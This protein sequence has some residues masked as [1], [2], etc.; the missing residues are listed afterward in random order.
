MIL[1]LFLVLAF[2]LAGETL[3]HLSPLPVPGPVIGMVLLAAAFALM[4]GLM[5]VLRPLSTT[6]LGNLSLLFVP[7]GV[8]IV[9]HAEL[10]Q[11]DGLAVVVAIAV[12]T[13]L[14][15]AASAL[16]FQWVARR[17][18]GDRRDA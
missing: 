9:G 10:L 7:A 17:L 4:P 16:T 12:S 1:P 3:A 2:Q 11:S 6:I 15:M 13:I 14:A 8:G 5:A 18:G